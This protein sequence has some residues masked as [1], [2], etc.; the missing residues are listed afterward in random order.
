MNCQVRLLKSASKPLKKNA[1]IRVHIGTAEIMARIVPLAGN[2][3]QPG[4]NGYAQ[5]K[6]EKPAATRRLDSFVIRRYSPALTIGGGIILETEAAPFRRRDTTLP[7]RLRALEKE[8]P[9]ELV[10]A[11]L[12]RSDRYAVNLDQLASEAG[13]KKEELQKLLK[14]LIDKK[15]V[16]AVGKRGYIHQQ[17]LAGLWQQLKEQLTEHHSKYPKE[18]GLR[19]ALISAIV[20]P[21]KDAVC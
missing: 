5:L 2:E 20:C 15:Q 10:I 8:E 4:Q 17:K 12:L 14:G 3:I 6:F 1:R 9:E 19:K 13:Y 16:F 21:L 18:I 11:Q 7:V